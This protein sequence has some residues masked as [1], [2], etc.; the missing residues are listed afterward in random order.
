MTNMTKLS[1]VVFVLGIGLMWLS[2]LAESR[3]PAGDLNSG[4]RNDHKRRYSSK[5][6]HDENVRILL[7]RLV[8]LEGKSNFL[9]LN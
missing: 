9:S 5:R 4:P 3:P 2:D 7:K 8:D 6:L 1:I